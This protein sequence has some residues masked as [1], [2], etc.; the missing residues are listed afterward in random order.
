MIKLVTLDFD[1]TTADTMPMLENIAV[2]LMV[3][4]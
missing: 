2:K 3:K 4:Y 1:G